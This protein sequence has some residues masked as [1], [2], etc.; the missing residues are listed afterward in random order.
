MFYWPYIYFSFEATSIIYRN[1]LNEI[2]N[3]HASDVFI[4][5]S[6]HYNYNMFTVKIHIFLIHVCYITY[7]RFAFKFLISNIYILYRKLNMKTI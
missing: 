3:L 6:S 7:W 2:L 5:N 4:I 1:F